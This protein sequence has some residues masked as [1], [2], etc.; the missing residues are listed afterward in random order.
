MAHVSR[1]SVHSNK[2]LRH[3]KSGERPTSKLVQVTRL[4]PV[5]NL[6]KLKPGLG[7]ELVP[8]IGVGLS[9][10]H[11]KPHAVPL[12][13]AEA[14]VHNTADM[15]YQQAQLVVGRPR[16]GKREDDDEAPEHGEDFAGLFGE[17]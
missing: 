11:G 12:P 8:I 6:N 2:S 7:T 3:E 10:A 9:H 17:E 5:S 4:R 15:L 16:G 1:P 13:P 14:C